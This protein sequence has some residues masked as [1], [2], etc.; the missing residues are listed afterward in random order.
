ML[1][2]KSTRATIG[3]SNERKVKKE[4]YGFDFTVLGIFFTL[5]CLSIIT[6]FYSSIEKKR[7]IENEYLTNVR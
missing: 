5:S 4:T 1:P 6:I 3:K 2:N 7:K